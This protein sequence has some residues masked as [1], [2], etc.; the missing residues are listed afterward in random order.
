M[1]I[2]ADGLLKLLGITPKEES[3]IDYEN[4]NYE[5][6]N[7]DVFKLDWSKI[8]QR[9][10]DQWNSNISRIID[11]AMEPYLKKN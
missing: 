8:P 5:D 4:L 10:K 2:N 9:K 3:K 11:E 7:L 1:N 6:N